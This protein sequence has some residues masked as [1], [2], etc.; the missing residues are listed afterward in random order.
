MAQNTQPKGANRFSVYAGMDTAPPVDWG[1]VA[2]SISG[3]LVDIQKEREGAKAQIEQDTLTQMESLNELGDVNNRSLSR[4]TIEASAASK[5]ELQTRMDMVRRGLIQPKDYKLFMQEQQNGYKSFSTA[6]GQ[7]DKWYTENKAMIDQKKS[8]GLHNYVAGTIESFGNLKDKKVLI[9]PANGQLQVV[10]MLQGDSGKY[11]KLPNAQ[12]QPTNYQNPNSILGL[13]NFKEETV[14]YKNTVGSSVDLIGK[15]I[16]ARRLGN[17]AVETIEDYRKSSSYSD[18]KSDTADTILTN[19]NAISDV[20]SQAGYTFGSTFLEAKKKKPNLTKEKFIKVDLSG[21]EPVVTLDEDQKKAAR[22]IVENEIDAQLDYIEKQTQGFDQNSSGATNTRDKLKSSKETVET[23]AKLYG[24]TDKQSMNSALTQLMGQSGL[25][26]KDF[27][28]DDD[29]NFIISYK[30][31]EGDIISN[32]IPKGN[33]VDDFIKNAYR[34]FQPKGS[35]LND[36]L[37]ASSYDKDLDYGAKMVDVMIDNPDWKEGDPESKRLI[38]KMEDEMIDGQ[39][40]GKQVPVQERESY[41]N[42]GQKG[43]NKP[44]PSNAQSPTNDSGGTVLSGITDSDYDDARSLNNVLDK[45]V[46]KVASKIIEGIAARANYMGNPELAEGLE[47]K[48]NSQEDGLIMTYN[49]V[50]IGNAYA[51]V[52]KEEFKKNVQDMVNKG[53]KVIFSGKS[54]NNP[55]SDAGEGGLD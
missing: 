45:G 41:R 9:N 28:E 29:G 1:T 27:E 5:K 20:L 54:P 7:W 22:A 17:G 18:W 43:S 26:Y 13:M 2:S 10:S 32:T 50:E 35:D 37:N 24:A 3:Q 49:G 33:N 8:T 40:T 23:L 48:L 55:S 34:F 4:V 44:Q 52:Q 11:D 16:K 19:D 46:N 47:V 12:K 36:A 14:N 6:I 21:E 30:D 38:V 42:Y 25:I 31:G 39:K 51:D 53:L 15:E